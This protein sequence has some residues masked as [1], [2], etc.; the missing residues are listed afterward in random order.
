M[1]RRLLVPLLGACAL[2]TGQGLVPLA[3][4]FLT[5]DA[6]EKGKEAVVTRT[7][8]ERVRTVAGPTALTFGDPHRA[9]AC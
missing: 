9:E 4:E 8:V 2:L 3:W 5:G 6:S 1:S 7:L